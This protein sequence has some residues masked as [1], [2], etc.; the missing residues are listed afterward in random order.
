[1]VRVIHVDEAIIKTLPEEER[2]DVRS[3]LNE[4]LEVND[5][6]EYGQA[7]VEMEWDRGEGQI[8]S[9][10]LGLSSHEMELVE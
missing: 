6:D 10:S 1:M 9:H 7:W 3:M 8:E 5:I 4:V 2:L